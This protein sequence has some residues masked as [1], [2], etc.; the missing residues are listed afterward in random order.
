MFES[1]Y[2]QFLRVNHSPFCN[3]CMIFF[4]FFLYQVFLG[5]I[6]TALRTVRVFFFFFG[7]L[8]DYLG[9]DFKKKKGGDNNIRVYHW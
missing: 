1:K 3:V 2:A 8:G 6:W 9:G 4:V 5:G 7:C